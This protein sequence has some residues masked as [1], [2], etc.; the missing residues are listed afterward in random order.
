MGTFEFNGE[1]YKI[2]SKHQKEWGHKLIQEL[3]LN[4]NEVILDLGCGDGF[5][6]R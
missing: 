3:E 6:F 5:E 2:A 1:K 4:G